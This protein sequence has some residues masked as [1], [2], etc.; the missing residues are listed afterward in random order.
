MALMAVYEK[1]RETADQVEYRFG[2]PEQDR[3]LLINKRDRSCLATG[4]MDDPTAQTLAG[5]IIHLERA[6][7]DWPARGVVAA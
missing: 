4:G 1:V 5:E 7:G 6:E 2:Y 3:R